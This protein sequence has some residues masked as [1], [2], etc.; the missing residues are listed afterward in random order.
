MLQLVPFLTWLAPV[1]SAVLLLLLASQGDLGRRGTMAV[2]AW[3]LIA[4]WCQ[5][6]AASALIAAIG[7]ALQTLLA[8][9][10]IVRWRLTA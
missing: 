8:V 6:F 7:L 1:T 4:G 5:F 9:Y 3:L 10:L 2:G